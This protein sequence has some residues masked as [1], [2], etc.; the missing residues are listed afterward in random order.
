MTS[1]QISIEKQLTT[2]S[3]IAFIMDINAMTKRQLLDVLGIVRFI[4]TRATNRLLELPEEP[5]R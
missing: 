1:E 2:L 5:T 4:K 3:E